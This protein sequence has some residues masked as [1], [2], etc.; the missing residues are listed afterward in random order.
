MVTDLNVTLN[1]PLKNSSKI[2]KVNYETDGRLLTVMILSDWSNQSNGK[3]IPN[4]DDSVV[5]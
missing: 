5:S 1:L 2:T 4:N 3:T